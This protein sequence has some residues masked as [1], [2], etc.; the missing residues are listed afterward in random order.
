MNPNSLRNA[1]GV[2]LITTY[3]ALILVNVTQS[4]AVQDFER[5]KVLPSSATR[6][7]QQR[8]SQQRE[9]G[10]VC[11]IDERSVQRKVHVRERDALE[12][13]IV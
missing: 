1:H 10:S 13:K 4:T 12:A 11:P 2:L 3:I 8:V 7:A 9:L 5:F 6:T